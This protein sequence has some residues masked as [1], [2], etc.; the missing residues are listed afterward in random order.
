MLFK[1][2]NRKK[3]SFG[4]IGILYICTG[5]YHIFWDEFYKSANK[6]FCKNSEVHY[7]V[8][9]E[10][11]INTFGNE[12][13]HH[14]VQPKLGW[15]YDTLKRFHLFLEQ[16]PSLEQM[17]YLYF[18]NANMVFKKKIKEEEILPDDK[19]NGLV[20]VLHSAFYDHKWTPPFEDNQESEAFVETNMDLNYFQGCLSGG[21]T[22]DYLRMAEEIKIMVEKDLKK[23]IIGKWW[24]ESY[25]NKYFILHPPK[26]LP[27]S[28]A[29]PQGGNL[30]MPVKI[31]MFEKQNFGGH[32]FLRQ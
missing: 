2:L 6:Y 5:K 9:T 7:Y 21:R 17:D 14:I 16:R 11:P 25:M 23:D 4:K 28:Y 26:P 8:F 15:P 24:D 19:G 20:S 18:F 12:K 13:V 29:Y 27:P 3:E 32:D 10:H 31:F 1:L 22:N 30:P